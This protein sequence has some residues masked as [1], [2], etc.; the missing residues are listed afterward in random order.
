MEDVRA[1]GIAGQQPWYAVRVRSRFEQAAAAVM[2][3][4]GFEEFVPVVRTRRRWSDRV[5]ELKAPMFAGYVFCRFD[6]Q[7]RNAILECPGVFNIVSFANQPI[8]VPDDEIQAVKVM[9]QST[10]PLAPYP[11]IEAGQKVRIDWGPLAGVEGVV[12]EVKK[13]F[14]LVASITLLQ[15]SVSVEINRDWVSPVRGSTG[16]SKRIGLGV[17]PHSDFTSCAHT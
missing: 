3:V 6:A 1:A 2:R 10:L 16:P 12:V 7:R 4:K 17:R 5:K 15:R 14:R 8:P 9:V 13:E 11:F